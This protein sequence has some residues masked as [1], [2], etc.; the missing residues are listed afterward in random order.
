MVRLQIPNMIIV[1]GIPLLLGGFPFS[2]LGGREL[3]KLR[4]ADRPMPLGSPKILPHWDQNIGL[5]SKDKP[6]IFSQDSRV[7]RTL[8]NRQRSEFSLKNPLRSPKA[9]VSKSPVVLGKK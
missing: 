8:S 9:D 1:V 2:S 6:S 7:L 3:V 5:F 4:S